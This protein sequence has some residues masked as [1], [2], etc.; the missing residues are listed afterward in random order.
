MF[1]GE[2]L[3]DQLHAARGQFV[4]RLDAPVNKLQKLTGQPKLDAIL[5]HPLSLSIDEVIRNRDV[6]VVS[7]AVGSFGEGSARVL[8]QFILHM[9]HRALIRQQE[10]PESERARVRVVEL[11]TSRFADTPAAS[12]DEDVG[13][14]HCCHDCLQWT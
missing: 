5:R 14:F 13:A 1:F 11:S 6:L 7:G 8:L 10:L 12:G 2:Q 9:V 4:P 3:P